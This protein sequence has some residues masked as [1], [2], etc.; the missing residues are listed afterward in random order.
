MLTAEEYDAIRQIVREE[1]QRVAGYP[2][3]PKVVLPP[4][5]AM[6]PIVTPVQPR[7]EDE[8]STGSQVKPN[9]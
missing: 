7:P 1:L 5:S 9:S 8:E 4:Q 3:V 2:G 6:P